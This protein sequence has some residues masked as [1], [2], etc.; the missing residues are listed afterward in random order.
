LISK[1]GSF[2][3]KGDVIDIYLAYEDYALR[4]EYFGDE[5]ERIYMI[6]PL[7]GEI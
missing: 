1:R 6:V 4:I 3:V 5:I 2:R 7:T